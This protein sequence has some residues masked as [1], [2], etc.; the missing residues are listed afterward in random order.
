M[1]KVKITLVIAFVLALGAGVVLGFAAARRVDTPPPVDAK[2]AEGRRPS[3]L[4]EQ[5][6]LSDQQSEQI[7]AI[8]Q[9]VMSEQGRVNTERRRALERERDAALLGLLTSEQRE[10]YDRLM[11]DYAARL[12]DLRKEFDALHQQAVER[13]RQ[14]LTAEQRARYEE[15]LKER[16][17]ERE[18]DREVRGRRRGGNPATLPGA[19]PSPASRPA[20]G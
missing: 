12:A 13:T 20:G 7:R 15:L 6:K 11:K 19:M 16:E 17:R 2:P 18:R 14:V 1:S 8:W 5:L 3:W 10:E 9:Q 4:K